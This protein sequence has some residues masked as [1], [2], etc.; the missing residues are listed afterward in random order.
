MRLTMGEKRTITK[1][2]VER[3]KKS[4]KKHKGII[5]KEFIELT[6]YNRSYASYVLRVYGLCPF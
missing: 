1:A 3:Y 5:L 2:F 6:G 4:R